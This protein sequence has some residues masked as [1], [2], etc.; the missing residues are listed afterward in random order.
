[1]GWKVDP[2]KW[3]CSTE[4]VEQGTT[5]KVEQALH[6]PVLSTHSN[7]RFCMK[8]RFTLLGITVLLLTGSIAAAGP[9]AS[10]VAPTSTLDTAT[11]STLASSDCS[12]D[13]DSLETIFASDG[14]QCGT[15]GHP[16]CSGANFGAYCGSRSDPFDPY[17]GSVSLYCQPTQL[18]A[19]EGVGKRRCVCEAGGNILH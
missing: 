2:L 9:A 11:I 10:A 4:H 14:P 5:R 8:A 19:G 18:C 6:N 1:M 12:K 7:R 15:C 16:N 3:I 13:T 17:G